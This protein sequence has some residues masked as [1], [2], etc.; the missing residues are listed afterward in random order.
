[1]FQR[2][3]ENNRQDGNW[4]M[5]THVEGKN[6]TR[7][8]SRIPPN[9]LP[10][11]FLDWS[12]LASPCARTSPHSAPDREVK[13]NVNIPNQLNVQSGTVPRHETIRASSPEEVI[14]PPPSNQV[15]EQ[16]VHAI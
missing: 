2:T 5:A 4:L 6:N 1:M 3:F 11:R 9:P 7:Q 14:V 8:K 15:E 12:S 13:Q 16:N 10:S